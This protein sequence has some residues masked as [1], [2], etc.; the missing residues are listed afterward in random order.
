MV[1]GLHPNTRPQRKGREGA[2][3]LTREDA[4]EARD[5]PP[6]WVGV[7]IAGIFIVLLL[8][9]G[10]ALW[11]VSANR[12]RVPLFADQAEARFHTAGP[13]L[14]LAPRADRLA[15]ARAH[16]APRGAVLEAAMESVLRQGWGDAAP[17]PSRAESALKRAEAGG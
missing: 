12:P 17:R 1:P 16:P 8:S 5:A 9:V 2:W 15:L 6:G 13:P 7:G 11:F 3:A 4:F 10:G 14:E